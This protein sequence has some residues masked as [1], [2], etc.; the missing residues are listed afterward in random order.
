MKERPTSVTVFSIINLVLSGLGVIGIIFWVLGLMGIQFGSAEGNPVLELMNSSPAYQLFTH[1]ATGVGVL[2]TILVIS[3]SIGMLTLKP[4][5]RTATIGCGVYSILMTIAAVAVNYLAIFGPLIADSSGPERIG[6]IVAV[7]IQAVISA[8]F[9]GY[10]LLM[11]FML[12]RPKVVEAFTPDEIDNDQ[13]GWGAHP[14]ETEGV[15][16][17]E[18]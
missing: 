14:S 6:M 4:W 18:L 3:A 9:I 1:I 8:L 10:Y 17:A 15:G 12:T 11:I 7:V 2:V 16:G 5:A 13:G